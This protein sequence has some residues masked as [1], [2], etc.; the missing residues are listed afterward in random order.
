MEQVLHFI[1]FY[2]IL[3][4]MC[5]ISNF[6][7]Y[8]FCVKNTLIINYFLPLFASLA[9]DTKP[10][11]SGGGGGMTLPLPLLVAA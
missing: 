2:F 8:V 10:W 9:K 1:L 11:V 6:L 5:F 4:S 7:I 3:N